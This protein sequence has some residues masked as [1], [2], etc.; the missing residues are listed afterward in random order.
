MTV[1]MKGSE[2]INAMKEKMII[3]VGELKN[4]GVIPGLG[5]IRLGVKPPD[6]AYEKGAIKRA[7][8]VG[9]NCKVFEY[10]ETIAQAELIHEIS[11]INA[12]K[13][14]HGILLFRP[15][16]KQID[17]RIIKHIIS[18]EK[19]I[20]CL[21]PINVAKVFSG[22][23]SGFAPCTPTA[24]MELLEYYKISVEGK[25]VVVIGRSLVVGKP[26]AMMLLKK[27]ATVTIC[28]TRT[29]NLKE[30]CREAEILIAA[31]GKAKMITA[32][33]ISQGGIVIDVGI[34]MDQV[35]KLCGDVDYEGAVNNVSYITPVPGGV[36][37][38]TSSVLAKHV[39]R[40]ASAGLL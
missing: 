12:D 23:E 1:I 6:L 19:D 26:L 22:D 25:K 36:G 24:V 15:L 34:N 5:I 2:V 30:L 31:A 27:N 38:V 18:P 17:E 9:I 4:K 33:F 13:A 7:E 14:I 16:P 28:H 11:K 32:D 39:I 20:D 37:T 29:R 21:N 40:G 8:S 35:G 3:E 10:P